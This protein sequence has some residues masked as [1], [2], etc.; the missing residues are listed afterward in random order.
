[1]LHPKKVGTLPVKDSE[2][3]KQTNEI[4][5]FIPLL[6]AIKID[7]KDITADALLTQR[8]L[9]G[10]LVDCGAH[11]HFTVKGNQAS[12]QADIAL[13]FE[14]R[15]AP[16]Y[17]EV[18]PPD[19]GRIEARRIWCSTAL[20]AYLDFPHVAQVFLIEREVFHKKSQKLTCETALGITSRPQEQA[21][22]QRLLT[23][24]R[25]HWAIENS[26]HYIIDWNYDEDRSR[27]SK[28]N[29]P[30]NMTRLRRFA[31]GVIK[32]FAKGKTSVA[33]KMQQL[34]R[35]VRLVFDYLRMT[36]NSTRGVTP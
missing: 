32:M 3:T 24:N 2:E 17:S 21:N 5:M 36:Q 35:K 1:M 6:D 11:Y 7:G 19:H 27:I 22:A 12:L 30:E 31:V 23:V 33:E 9:A 34:N 4:G 28:G 18:T 25:G 16:D 26:C 8:K 14:G 29:G 13:L 15:G 20:N 10:Y